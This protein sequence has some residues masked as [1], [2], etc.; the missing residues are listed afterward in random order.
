MRMRKFWKWLHL[1]LSIP[2]GILVIVLCLSGAVLVFQQELQRLL[3]PGFYYVKAERASALPLDSLVKAALRETESLNKRMTSFTVYADKGRTWDVGVAGQKGAFLTLD[4]YTGEVAGV[5]APGREFFTEVRGLH[6]WLMLGG[7]GRVAG[8]LIIGVSTLFFLVI[9]VSGV[10]LAFPKRKAQW[11]QFLAVKRGRAWWYTSHRAL[12]WYCL[13]FLFL[14]AAT[15][16]MWSFGWYRTGVAKLF[17][18]EMSARNGKGGGQKDVAALGGKE[19]MM[20]Q[21][22]LASI[23]EEVPDY[24]SVSF[25]GNS[26]TVK[27]PRHH[28]R[29]SDTYY[30]DREGKIS[31]MELYEDLPSS[32]KVMGYAF[33]LHT[34]TWGGW[35]VK[36]LYFLACAGG[37]Y[38]AVSGYW[39]YC[40][41]T[42]HK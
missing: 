13:V 21:A 41:R 1:W 37:V 26:A 33:L 30:F 25:R 27:T 9:L 39:L 6:R 4:P 14:M 18:V 7:E 32:R 34:G 19:I 12:G 31:R 10:V 42:F 36:L 35:F 2:A 11:R 17:G 5:E 38:L 3:N 8:R 15:G 20:W 22:A 24:I 28:V 29:G 16:P 40:K 23:R